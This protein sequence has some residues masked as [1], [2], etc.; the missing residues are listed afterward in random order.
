MPIFNIMPTLPFLLSTAAHADEPLH[1]S[2]LLPNNSELEEIIKNP[3]KKPNPNGKK[4]GKKKKKEINIPIEI[5]LGPTFYNFT[6]TEGI[7][8]HFYRGIST[9]GVAIISKKLIRQNKHMIPKQY[10]K[11][12]LSQDEFRITKLWIP[13][14]IIMTSSLYGTSAYG[15]SFRPVSLSLSKAKK[16][17]GLNADIGARL[18]YAYVNDTNKDLSTHFFRLGLDGRA[19]LRVPMGRKN[20]LGIGWTSQIYMPQGFLETASSENAGDIVPEHVGQI[21]IKYYYRFPYKYKL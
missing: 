16:N 3:P 10:R 2:A 14:S 7:E 5:G 19:E 17:K 12:A 21:S 1:Q 13:D 18:T 8:P 6:N 11:F 15:A 9:S 20:S 4:K